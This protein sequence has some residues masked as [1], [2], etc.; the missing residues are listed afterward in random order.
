MD[1]ETVF[2]KP[3]QVRAT[4]LLVKHNESRRPSSWRE[5]KIT[6]TKEEAKALI[7]GY[8]QQ[9]EDH[10][11]SLSELATQYSD[12]SSAKK[13]GDLGYFSRG[14]MQKAFEEATFQLQVGELSEPVWTDSGVHIIMRTA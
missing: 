5:E 6:R 7:E 9:V 14:Q 12:C 10:H 4:H 3:D 11:A 13:G 2:S 8:R 1:N